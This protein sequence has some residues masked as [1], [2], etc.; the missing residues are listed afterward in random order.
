MSQAIAFLEGSAG[1]RG[2]CGIPSSYGGA[3]CRRVDSLLIIF[4]LIGTGAL[5]W[6]VGVLFNPRLLRLNIPERVGFDVIWVLGVVEVVMCVQMIWSML[7]HLLGDA[8]LP[9]LYRLPA[10]ADRTAGVAQPAERSGEA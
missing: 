9:P 3:R 1:R 8:L 10:E 6:T 4:S 7:R 2:S 5:I